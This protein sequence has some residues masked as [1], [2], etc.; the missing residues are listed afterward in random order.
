MNLTSKTGKAPFRLAFLGAIMGLITAG[1]ANADLI[2]FTGSGTGPGSVPVAA[3]AI[4]DISGNNLTITL[5]NTSPSNSGQDVPGSTLTGLFWDSASNTALTPFSA[6]LATGSTIYN[7]SACNSS[8]D[9]TVVTNLG[10][11]FGYQATSLTGGANRGISSSGYLTT[12]QTGNLGNFNGS[13]LSDPVSLDGINFGIISSATGFNPNGGNGGLNSVPL[14][15]DSVVFVLTGVN[16]LS[17]TDISNVSF[18]YGTKLTELN[19]PGTPSIPG[20]GGQEP[21][22]PEPNNLALL[23]LGLIAGGFALRRRSLLA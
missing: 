10:G 12:G 17:I 19:V 20:G 11:E 23:G 16:G 15:Q 9:C 4:F 8:V 7:P 2:T 6:T 13:N 18:Q 22:V 21:N 5:T 1:S 14:I 3:S